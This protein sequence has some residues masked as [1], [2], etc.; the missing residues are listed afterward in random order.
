MYTTEL[1]LSEFTVFNKCLVY[2]FHTC[3]Y[4]ALINKIRKKKG[5]MSGKV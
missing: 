1:F 4:L 2:I 5:V 3:I